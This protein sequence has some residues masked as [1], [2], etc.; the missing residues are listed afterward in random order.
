LDLGCGSGILS[1]IAAMLGAKGAVAADID[2]NCVKTALENAKMNGVSPSCYSA[3][4]GDLLSEKNLREK[5]AEKKYGLALA[6]I[7]PEVITALL[8]FIRDV[9]ETSGVAVLSGIIGRYLPDVESA[10]KSLGFDIIGITSENDWQCLE[11]KK[12]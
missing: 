3:Y 6:N 5:I 4:A 2:E 1:I 8:P 9:L 7:V 12:T 10:A 11:V